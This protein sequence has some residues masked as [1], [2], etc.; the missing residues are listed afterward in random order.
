MPLFGPKKLARIDFAYYWS[1]HES[2]Y[3]EKTGVRDPAAMEQFPLE[4]YLGWLTLHQIWSLSLPYKEM[5]RDALESVVAL[6]PSSPQRRHLVARWEQNRVITLRTTWYRH[7]SGAILPTVW[8]DLGAEARRRG[9]NIEEAVVRALAKI[10]RVF[11][12]EQL[13]SLQAEEEMAVE[14]ISY[15]EE[16]IRQGRCKRD[17]AHSQRLAALL[18]EAREQLPETAE[19]EA[20]RAALRG[21]LDDWEE[22]GFPHGILG[23]QRVRGRAHRF[24]SALKGITEVHGMD[25]DRSS[26]N[27]VTDPSSISTQIIHQQT[28]EEEELARKL[29][30]LA[31]LETELA[32]REL[33]LATL[34][35]ELHLFERRYLHVAGV[36]YAE[37]D[38]LRALIAEA[39][40]QQTPYD[41]EARQDAAQGRYRAEESAQA[42]GA[43]DA[44]APEE[45]FQPSENLKKL[46]REV[47]RRVHPDLATD[48]QERAR[49]TR[50]MAEAASAYEEGNE[51]R[52]QAILQEW[53]TS[54]EAVSGEGPGVQLV[55][56]IREIAQVR[57]R[58]DAIGEEMT[59]LKG[60]SLYALKSKVEEAE[61][62]SRDLLA[63]MAAA[64]HRQVAEAREELAGIARPGG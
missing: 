1:D 26:P 42:A 13:W 27:R 53:E 10:W 20:T 14:R 31:A 15:Y 35:S 32:Q 2:I 29:A 48:E 60:S 51:A 28:P 41:P 47:A 52:L 11:A 36:R 7:R 37:L 46:F 40:A 56:A 45:R 55:R 59:R 49:R 58:L 16:S 24:T 30:E 62:E 54:P 25:T 39:R 9:M 38:E 34:V 5:L 21:L 19:I 44:Q 50:L 61:A 17:D 6:D 23:A 3:V 33:D 18:N 22:N 4:Y 64:L 63:E 12:N 57:A 8:H 43:A